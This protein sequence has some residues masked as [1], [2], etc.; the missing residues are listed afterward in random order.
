[1]AALSAVAVDCTDPATEF[2]S[3]GS[4]AIELERELPFVA[5]FNFRIV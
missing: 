1:M 3:V 5:S 2:V 4:V